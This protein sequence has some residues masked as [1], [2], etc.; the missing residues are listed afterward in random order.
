MSIVKNILDKHIPMLAMMYRAWLSYHR[1]NRPFRT[2]KDFGFKFLGND[3]MVAGVF[4]IDEVRI[5]HELLPKVHRFVDV[6]AN[7]GYYTCI[8]R[9]L[10]KPCIAFEPL[11][12]NLMALFANLQAN[13]WL[14]TEIWPIGLADHIGMALIFVSGGFASLIRGWA[15]QLNPIGTTICINTL[16]NVMGERFADERLFVKIDVEG[17]EMAVLRGAQVFFSRALK[18]ILLIEISLSQN[19]PETNKDYFSTFKFFWDR[20]YR[21]VTADAKMREVTQ[22]D[23]ESWVRQGSCNWDIHNWLALPKDW[24]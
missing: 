24:V 6:G 7:I 21:L 11:Q 12:S 4:E 3:A 2:N 19:H 23:V 9:Q 5:I 14:D 8:A 22:K 18:P 15:K 20:G 10:G 17:L 16:D 1:I 13:N